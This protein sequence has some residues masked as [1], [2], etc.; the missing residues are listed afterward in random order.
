M[1]VIN[2][3]L[4]KCIE[5]KKNGL[6]SHLIQDMSVTKD[7]IFVANEIQKLTSNF[8]KGNNLMNITSHTTFSGVVNLEASLNSS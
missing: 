4:P 3:F 8:Y 5:Q 6:S 1:M 2:L 7:V